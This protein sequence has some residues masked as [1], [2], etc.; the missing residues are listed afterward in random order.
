MSKKH[1]LPLI[2]A[3]ICAIF[4][5]GCQSINSAEYSEYVPKDESVEGGFD[6]PSNSYSADVV[7]DGYLTD[8]KWTASETV[9]L[10]SWD[11][12]DIESGVYGAIVADTNNYA[13]SKR[14]IIKMFRGNVGLH[15]GFEVKDSD[16]AYKEL[17][18]NKFSLNFQFTP[19][20]FA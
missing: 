16:I 14:A 17:A 5:F 1:L 12:S 19:S 6:F 13:N 20:I 10:G 11:N 18:D 8:E 3:L 7:L 2:M 4:L 15:F 9:Q